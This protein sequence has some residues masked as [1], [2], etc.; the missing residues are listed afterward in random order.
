MNKDDDDLIGSLWLFSDDVK[1]DIALV[2]SHNRVMASN[3]KI[4]GDDYYSDGGILLFLK[5]HDFYKKIT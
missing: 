2:L 4:Y 3:G 5:N 1:H